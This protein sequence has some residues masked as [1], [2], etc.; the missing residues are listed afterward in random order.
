M[1]DVIHTQPILDRSLWLTE[2]DAD[3]LAQG[4][5]HDPFSILGIHNDDEGQ[6]LRVFL[7]G[8][9]G[10]DVLDREGGTSRCCLTS[11][12]IPG[13]FAARLPHAA[14]YLLHIRW[15]Q[16]EQI[17]E[18][19]YSFGLLLG[20]MDLYLLG[21]GNH[22]NLGHCLGA[23]PMAVDGVD[24]VRFSVWAPNAKRV[25]VVGNFNSWDGR[26]HMMRLRISAGVWEIF[27]PRIGPGEAYKYEI[28]EAQG[29]IGLRADP[30][31]LATEAPPSTASV[32]ADTTPFT[33][34]DE[35]WIAQRQKAHDP[36]RPISIYE[37][38]AAS[39]RKHGGDNGELYSWRDL[40]EQLI[41]YVLEM[42]FTHVELLPIM[43]HPFG[44]SWGYQPLGQFAPSGW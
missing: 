21:E 42:G 44:G 12:Q 11:M 7:P 43:E 15:P 39:W 40:A 2:E 32:V 3:A 19:P 6:F 22:R 37:V 18:D 5:H 31:A 8:A 16:G 36:S 28:V 41:P 20:E 10:V 35:E 29:A 14:P 4:T 25:S 13:L 33:W 1:N 26:R 23:Q 9:V 17:T 38:H 34:H 27:V 24:G 30:V